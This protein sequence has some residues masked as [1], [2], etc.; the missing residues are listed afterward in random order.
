MAQGIGPPRVAVKTPASRG[1]AAC[2]GPRLSQSREL[3]V[4]G[5]GLLCEAEACRAKR[6][7][8]RGGPSSRELVGDVPNW[9]GT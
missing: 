5:R 4:R 1:R 6:R 9:S 7:L 8:L 2:R 3:L